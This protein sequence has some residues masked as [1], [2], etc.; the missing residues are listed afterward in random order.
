[1]GLKKDLQQTVA[2]GSWDDSTGYEKA[3]AE[4]AQGVLFDLEAIS[5]LGWFIVGVIVICALM[6]FAQSIKP[7]D[8]FQQNTYHPREESW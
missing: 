6:F 2:R 4:N 3:E 8:E 7:I 5:L 1:M